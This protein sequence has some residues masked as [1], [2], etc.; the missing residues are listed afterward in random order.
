MTGAS[1]T[2]EAMDIIERLFILR[3]AE[4]IGETRLV[5]SVAVDL[6]VK[7][8]IDIH[9]LVP[10]DSS[11]KTAA[12]KLSAYLLD[13]DSVSE[14]RITDYRHKEAMK[15]AVDSLPGRSGSWSMDV[16]ITSNR[17]MT[18]FEAANTLHDRLDP[19]SRRIIMCIKSHYHGQQK[20]RDGM[21]TRI[22]DAVLDGGVRSVKEFEEYLIE[23]HW[24]R[25]E[26]E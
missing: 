11:V 9:V 5:G 4:K 10:R 1:L 25:C 24:G 20:L 14:V 18:G 8:D 16:W 21:S 17:D 19:D 7:R 2:V 15:V 3:E 22:Y 6:V 23:E 12:V 13:R 26:D